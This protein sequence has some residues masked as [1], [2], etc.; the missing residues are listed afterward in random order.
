[1]LSSAA[2]DE[3]NTELDELFASYERYL[4]QDMTG[5]PNDPSVE[6]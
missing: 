2:F 5:P 6:I 3:P 4:A 1:M